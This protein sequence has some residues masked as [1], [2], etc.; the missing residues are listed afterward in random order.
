MTGLFRPNRRPPIAFPYRSTLK[1][2]LTNSF[3][4]VFLSI[5]FD[6]Q[7]K[8][9]YNNWKGYQ[10]YE[11]VMAGANACIEIIQQYKCPCLLNDNRQ[12]VGPW[13]H[14]TDWIA[15]DWT[16]RALK[17]GMKYFAHVV[18]KQTLAA[19]SAEEM[20]RKVGTVFEMK[21]FDNMEAAKAWLNQCR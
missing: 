3:G 10:S 9:V 1:K 20:H 19:M 21:V 13:D 11:N 6:N 5:E 7:N 14:A 8:W 18:D 17:A 2:D 12:V 16:P 4:N 15:N